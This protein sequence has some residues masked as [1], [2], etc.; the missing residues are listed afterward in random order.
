M[1]H[2]TFKEWVDD[3]LADEDS[4]SSVLMP[5]AETSGISKT[6]LFNL[7]GGARI[8]RYDKALAVSRATAGVVKVA[9]IAKS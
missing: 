3:Q 2:K 9:E 5:L 6:T 7:Y 1:K 4:L 8:A